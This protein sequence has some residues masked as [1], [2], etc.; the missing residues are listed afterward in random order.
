MDKKDKVSI[1]VFIL[2]FIIAGFAGIEFSKYNF[3]SGLDSCIGSYEKCS[4]E[5]FTPDLSSYNRLGLSY[6]IFNYICVFIARGILWGLFLFAPFYLIY[7]KVEG[8]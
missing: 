4:K 7:T 8:E 6:D 5:G 1:I 3:Y 2:C